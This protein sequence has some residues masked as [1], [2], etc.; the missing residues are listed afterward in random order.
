MNGKLCRFCCEKD[1]P[2]LQL[3]M[4]SKWFNKISSY[5]ISKMTVRCYMFIFEAKR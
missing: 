4:R 5:L 3:I 2:L 1:V